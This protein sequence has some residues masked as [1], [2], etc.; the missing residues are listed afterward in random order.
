MSTYVFYIHC[1]LLLFIEKCRVSCTPHKN[2]CYQIHMIYML[3]ATS[4]QGTDNSG[5]TWHRSLLTKEYDIQLSIHWHLNKP[6][7]RS[8]L[9]STDPKP[10]CAAINYSMSQETR[11][12]RSYD[13]R[14]F[15]NMYILQKYIPFHHI[16]YMCMASSFI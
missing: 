10:N 16:C 1:N 15:I 8:H 5:Q 9:D 2:L 7:N 13:L 6:G 14:F 4:Y 12:I 11:L 3:H